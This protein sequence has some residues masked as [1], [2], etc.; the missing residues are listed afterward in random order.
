MIKIALVA[1]AFAIAIIFFKRLNGEVAVVL[2]VACG[3]VLIAMSLDLLNEA[4]KIF[5]KIYRLTGIEEGYF[6]IIIKVMAI[7][8]LVEFTA[9]IMEDFGL[10]SLGDKLIF[11]GKIVILIISA[12]V[13]YKI[14]EVLESIV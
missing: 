6:K 14:I 13:F 3:V 2:A 1:I 8:Y 9:G 4:F 7:C 10:K 11:I 12:P 5:D